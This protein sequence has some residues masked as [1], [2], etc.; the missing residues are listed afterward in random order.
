MNKNILLYILCFFSAIGSYAQS[1]IAYSYDASGNRI[2]RTGVSMNANR[3]KGIHQK[4]THSTD[5]QTNINTLSYDET[6]NIINV[7]LASN[8][9]AE[10]TKLSVFSIA[11]E[12]VYS[13]EIHKG[14]NIVDTSSFPSGTYVAVII[15]GQKKQSIKFAKK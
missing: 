2:S 8:Q 7:G 3:A 15:A 12:L 1:P 6:S 4:N 5:H 13:C 14:K 11:G 10:D 9:L